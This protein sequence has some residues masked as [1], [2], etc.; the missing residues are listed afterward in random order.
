MPWSDGQMTL[1]EEDFP[2]IPVL[3]V[4]VE[5]F[6]H[7]FVVYCDQRH[8]MAKTSPSAKGVSAWK[9]AQMDIHFHGDEAKVPMESP[10]PR[11]FNAHPLH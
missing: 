9:V 4:A 3:A 2:I 10:F 7:L 8:N 5:S 1:L 11:L 6:G